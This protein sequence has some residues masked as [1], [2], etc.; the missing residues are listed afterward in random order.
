MKVASVDSAPAPVLRRR[1]P[2]GA[3]CG[4]IGAVFGAAAVLVT[5]QLLCGW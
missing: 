4:V 5:Q 3:L 1:V 2:L